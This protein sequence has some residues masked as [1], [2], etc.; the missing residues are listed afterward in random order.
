MDSRSADAPP[1]PAY[2]RLAAASVRSPAPLPIAADSASSVATSPA[3]SGTAWASASR[4]SA[5][6]GSSAGWASTGNQPRAASVGCT[7][8]ASSEDLPVPDAPVSTE[9]G[10]TATML[11]TL[12]PSASRPKNSARCSKP[13][14]STPR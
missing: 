7:I 13:K 5:A 3:G 1:S 9:S 6:S 4:R 14:V 8:A 12:R 10:C 2:Q 11:A